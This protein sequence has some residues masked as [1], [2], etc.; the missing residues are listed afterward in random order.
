MSAPSRSPAP[1]HRLAPGTV[2]RIAAGEVVERPASVVK[3]LVENAYDAGAAS[4][5]VRIAGGG[6]DRI[7]VADDGSGIAGDDLELAVERHATS[8]LP[9]LG[10][11][12]RIATLGFRGEALAAIG[13][14]SRLRLLSRPAAAAA[15]EGIEVVG[16]ARGERFTEARAPGTTVRVTELFFNTPARRKFL[17]AA[18][19]EQVEVV[20][21]LEQLYLARPSVGLR[22]S[23]EAGELLSLPASSTLLE[24]AARV[25]GGEFPERSFPVTGGAPGTV[26]IEAVLGRPAL[27]GATGSGL[28]V[29]VNGRPVVS[30]GVAQAVRLGFG[31]TIPRP[32]FPVGV[33]HLTVPPGQLDVNVHPT[34]R[35]VRFAAP[36]AVE[37]ELRR[38]VRVAL[39]RVPSPSAPPRAAAPGSPDADRPAP[40]FELPFSAST[41]PGRQRQLVGLGDPGGPSAVPG[42]S[43]R[44]RLELL[45]A[46]D[47]LYWVASSDDGL[48]LIDQ[49]AASERLLYAR[50]LEGGTIARQALVDPV[51]LTL[52][53]AQRA[54]LDANAAAVRDAG[55][56]VERFGPTSYRVRSVPAYRGRLVRAEELLGLLRELSDGGRPTVP[57]GV[58]ERRAASIA[59]HAA[60]RAGDVIE[61]TTLAEILS[62]LDR[63]SDRPRSC[64]HGRP[65]AVH[66]PRSRLDRWFL[67]SGA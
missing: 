62:G 31:E 48:L 8:K 3:E 38:A 46:I 16:G 29:A 45:G 15:A 26:A 53:A 2:E 64:P 36:R 40:T 11:V 4:V 22:L 60:V 25:L 44:P 7:E 5:V 52:T 13:S 12:E 28:Y 19:R 18:A 33:V 34:K 47:A 43:G 6:L 56:E 14:V 61:R 66:L 55:F 41:S 10:P 39:D 54:E 37:D 50:L 32:R 49:H 27:A 1:I 35:E 59:C 51:L 58:A 9:A 30:R 17:H 63:L 57:D 23:G 21:T 67:R 65:I 24:A 20:R 42:G